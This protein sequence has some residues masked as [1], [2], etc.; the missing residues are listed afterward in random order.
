MKYFETEAMNSC[1]FFN[2]YMRRNVVMAPEWAHR[3]KDSNV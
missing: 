1:D 3:V 2:S